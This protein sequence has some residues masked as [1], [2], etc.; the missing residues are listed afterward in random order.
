MMYAYVASIESVKN[1]LS[2]TVI[3]L[4]ATHHMF[5]LIMH[6]GRMSKETHTSF[7]LSTTNTKSV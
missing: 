5:V 3:I 6:L 7:G 4:I 2:F 1:E